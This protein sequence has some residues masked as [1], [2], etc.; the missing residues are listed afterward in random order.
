MTAPPTPQLHNPDLPRGAA[1]PPTALGTKRAQRLF[2]AVPRGA[3]PVEIKGCPPR[4]DPAKDTRVFAAR[5]GSGA[6]GTAGP[7]PHPPPPPPLP[8][9]FTP[10]QPLI[11][12]CWAPRCHRGPI[13]QGRLRARSAPRGFG[14]GGRLR[15]A[16]PLR[17]IPQEMPPA[18]LS[19]LFLFQ[20]FR[21]RKGRGKSSRA[22]AGSC[23]LH[24]S[25]KTESVR[26]PRGGKR[27]EQGIAFSSAVSK[28]S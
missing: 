4:S 26:S 6:S 16:A 23:S 9:P 8:A 13:A 1:C 17:P 22:I 19:Y 2:I 5:T 11:L 15:V 24:R 12:T 7:R 28:H 10:R 27:T 20:R 14:S 18:L 25:N 3:D 21:E